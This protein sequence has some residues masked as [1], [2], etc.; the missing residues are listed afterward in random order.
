M[1]HKKKNDGEHWASFSDMMTGLMVVF[2]FISISYMIEI[3]QKDKEREHLL[4][5]L[6]QEKAA[7]D[8]LF[9]AFAT[10]KASL[11]DELHATFAKEF[12]NWDMEL[13]KDLSIRF[14]NPDILFDSGSTQIKPQFADILKDFLPRY[15][16]LLL[17]PQY[18]GKIAEI[19][20]EG[21]TDRQPASW[22]DKD[23]YMANIK[24]SQARAASILK[25]LRELPF[26]QK[27]SPQQRDK[28]EF[29]TTANGLSYGRTLDSER[30]LTYISGQPEDARLSRRVEFRI[31]P[32]NEALIQKALQ[33]VS[34]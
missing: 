9:K 23:P 18:A 28:I 3:Q 16:K 25:F 2:M 12:T 1:S 22:L 24:L 11:Y 27:L 6:K 32:N 20:I 26:Y 13:D 10:T 5:E 4:L 17:Q 19:R 14:T 21:H 7:Q 29:L 34:K 33:T 30:H 8:N 15:F 31:V